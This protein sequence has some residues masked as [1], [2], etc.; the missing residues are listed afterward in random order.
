MASFLVAALLAHY[1]SRPIRSLRA[2]FRNAAAGNLATAV[3]HRMARR[4]DEL[5][6]LLQ[7]FDRMARKLHGMMES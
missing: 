4:N 1:F 5:S 7:E 2:A 3:D 6:D